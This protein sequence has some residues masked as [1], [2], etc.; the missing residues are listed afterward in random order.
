MRSWKE[1][2]LLGRIRESEK[3]IARDKEHL[4]KLIKKRIDEFGYGCDLNDIDVSHVVDMSRLFEMSSFNGDISQWDVSSV[5][6][7]DSMF[8]Y[9]NF[10]GDISNW[11]VSNVESLNEI[12]KASAFRGDASSLRRSKAWLRSNRRAKTPVARN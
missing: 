10:N 9:S 2:N 5:R 1:D 4:M 6:N 11:D 7:M 8:A 12:F 3:V